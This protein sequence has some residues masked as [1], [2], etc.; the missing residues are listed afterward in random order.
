MPLRAL[1]SLLGAGPAP[2]IRLGPEEWDVFTRLVVDR[3]RVAPATLAALERAGT[4]APAEVL[5]R[6]RAEARDNAFAALAQ[7]AETR[8]VLT[9]LAE[10]GCRPMLL[11]GWPLA[12]ELAGSAAGRHSKDL[13]L[14]IAAEERVACYEVLRGLGYHVAAHHRGRLPLLAEPALAAECNDLELRHENGGQVE[15]HWRSNH[16]R[17]WPDLR[18]LAGAGREWPLDGTGLRVRVPSPAAN[19][20]YL[21]LHGQQHAWL[22]LKWLYDIA[23][24]MRRDGGGKLGAALE[25]ARAAGAG[26]AVVAAV[27]LAHRV[28]GD[29]LPPGWPRPDLLA[30]RTIAHVMA[31]IAAENAEPLSP[32]AR[33]D[34]YWVA[35]LMAEGAGQRLGVLRYAFWRGPRL[36]LAGRRRALLRGGARADG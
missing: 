25:T 7:K 18:A 1:V 30:R 14:Y 8:R 23:C 31:G 21:A 35:L 15:I 10:R 20:V 13:D 34:F 26:R 24:L 28:F 33:F 16:F 9:A 4:P 19:L 27:H 17:G 11:K 29:P 2:E 32:R 22:R 36:F 3:H 6:I 5:E 12:E